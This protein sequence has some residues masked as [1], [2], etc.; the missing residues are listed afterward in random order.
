[1]NRPHLK[2]EDPKIDNL[3]NEEKN[4]QNSGLEMIPSE[5]H[6]TEAVLEA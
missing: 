6:T 5:N 1:M 2:Q 4:R 3:I